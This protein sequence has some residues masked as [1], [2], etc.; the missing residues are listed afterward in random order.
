MVETQLP[1]F[2][3]PLDAAA[4]HAP[5]PDRKRLRGQ[6]LAVLERLRQG[7]ATSKELATISLKYTSRI[8]DLRIA[9]YDITAERGEGG[10]FVY[11]LVENITGG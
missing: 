7:S 1:L 4:S 8:S 2:G 11:R 9:G 3:R 5:A 10:V 6:C